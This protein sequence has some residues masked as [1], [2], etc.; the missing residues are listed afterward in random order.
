[1]TLESEGQDQDQDQDQLHLAV[2]AGGNATPSCLLGHH[3]TSPC[4]SRAQT[5][6]GRFRP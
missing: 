3:T 1:M 2:A 4:G 6:N 5:W